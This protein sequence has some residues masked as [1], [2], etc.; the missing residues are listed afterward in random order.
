VVEGLHLVRDDL[1]SFSL[2]EVQLQDSAVRGQHLI[3][4]VYTGI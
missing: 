3:G 2:L 1:A 4:V